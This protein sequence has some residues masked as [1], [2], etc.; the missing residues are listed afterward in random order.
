MLWSHRNKGIYMQ[1]PLAYGEELYCCSDS[2]TLAVFDL[3]TGEQL[4]RERLGA[5]TGFSGSAV[6]AD[7]KLYFSG[8]NG[9]VFVVA[10]GL[11]FELLGSGHLGENH[12]ATPAISGGRL[13][14]H[15][16]HHVIAVGE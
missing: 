12:L 15:T 9:D 11:D 6:A 5:G 13:F 8:E 7:G 16:Q 1:T 10:A 3:G 2:G 14:F 4:Y